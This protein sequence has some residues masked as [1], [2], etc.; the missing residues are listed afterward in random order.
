MA[1]SFLLEAGCDVNA[2]TLD[3]SFTA[4]HY[5]IMSNQVRAQLRDSRTATLC[6]ALSRA[7]QAQIVSELL[8]CGAKA[9]LACKQG[10]ALEIAVKLK[11]DAIVALLN[12]WSAR[13]TQPETTVSGTDKVRFP[14]QSLSEHRTSKCACP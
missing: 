7:Q 2:V 11:L 6:C 5:A 9:S 8:R 4:I 13:P 12:E 10:D 14:R 3:G 1:V